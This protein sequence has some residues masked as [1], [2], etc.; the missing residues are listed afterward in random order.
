M[1]K[2]KL[3]ALA[4]DA[5]GSLAGTTFTKNRFGAVARQK[6]SPVQ[7]R[8]ARQLEQRSTFS[9]NSRGWRALTDAQRAQWNV[10][11][12]N[13]PITDVFGDSQTLGGNA[14][15]L[16]VNA[17]LQT[18]GE[19]VVSVPLADPTTPPPAASSV[20]IT[21]DDQTVTVTWAS[22][23]DADD[24]YMVYCTAGKSAGASFVNSDYRLAFAG[25]PGT[26]ATLAVV[27]ATK[28]ERLAFVTDQKVG[29]LV[30]RFSQDGA[31]IDSA[32]FLEVVAAT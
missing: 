27:P 28:N 11:A 31:L 10:Y 30:V 19:A 5:R 32:S 25:K 1:A 17:M 2:I 21:S 13:H 29:V 4:Q 24:L 23:P 7:P 22:T 18:L 15:Y 16:Q 12:T 3:G 9:A 6:V 8:T 26:A 20:A 14:A